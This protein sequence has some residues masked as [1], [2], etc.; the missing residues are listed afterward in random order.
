MVNY[1]KIKEYINTKK[2]FEFA[3]EILNRFIDN[4]DVKVI[5][6]VVVE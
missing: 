1:M 6:C 3:T 2:Q 4:E 5:K